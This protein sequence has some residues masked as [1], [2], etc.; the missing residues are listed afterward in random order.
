M[1]RVVVLGAGNVAQHLIKA[2]QKAEQVHLVQVWARNTQGLAGLIDPE[3]VTDD[4]SK[5]VAADVYIIAVSDTA[6]G[7]ISGQLPIRDAL[8]VHTSGSV[9][10]DVLAD[11]NR[12]GVFYPLQTFSKLKA[13]DFSKVP[14]CLEATSAADYELLEVIAL[15]LS[16]VVHA[17]NS[18]QRKALH[19]SAVFVCNFVNHLYVMG[20][21]ICEAHQL[22][23][24]LLQPLIQETAQK[25]LTLSPKEAQTGPAKRQDTTTINAHL[26]FL[27]DENQKEIYTL[28]TKSIIDHGKKL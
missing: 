23:F 24:S 21:E 17:V 11:H 7:P 2:F 9:A 16:G 1:T 20:E 4:L 26:N 12:K 15:S 10:L 25:I 14:I 28:L 3:L 22:D 19:V 8:V 13:V 6:I 27:T 5:I 18:A